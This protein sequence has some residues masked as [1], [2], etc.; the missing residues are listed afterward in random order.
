MN[1]Y[2]FFD[3]DSKKISWTIKTEGDCVKQTRDHPEIYLDKV[4]DLQSKYIALHVGIFWGIGVFIIKN[5][6]EVN[7]MIGEKE[8]FEHLSSSKPH[9][10]EFIEKRTFFIKNLVNQRKLKINYHFET[11]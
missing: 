8:M 3:G 6:D 4:N 2:F 9:P 5:N 10:D 1:H 7:V 11:T